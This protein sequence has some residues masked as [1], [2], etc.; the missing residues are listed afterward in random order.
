[1]VDY[2]P[3]IIVG[4]AR[5]GMVPAVILSKSLGVKD[6]FTLLV[7]RAGERRHI[8]NDITADI[9]GKN[10]LLVEDMIETG[11]GLLLAKQ[12]LEGKG[13]D[14]K[15]ACL[16]IMPIS[17]IKPDYFLTTVS[18]VMRFPWSHNLVASRDTH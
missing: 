10:I 3:D 11:R 17:E 9:S 8:V 4:I 14:V 18:E 6:T 13:A 5:G 2:Q 16:Y 1:M 12:H 15:T 7:K